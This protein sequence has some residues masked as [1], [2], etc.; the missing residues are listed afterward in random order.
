LRRAGAI[1]LD[2][3]ARLGAEFAV[4]RLDPRTHHT[5]AEKAALLV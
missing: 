1:D 2:A 3:R 4:R 5:I